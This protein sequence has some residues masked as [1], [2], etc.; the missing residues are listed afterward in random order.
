MVRGKKCF[1]K[2]QSCVGDEDAMLEAVEW[3]AGTLARTQ[4]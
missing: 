3:F 1:I 2:E 4:S